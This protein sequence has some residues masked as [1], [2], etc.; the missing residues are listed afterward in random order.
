MRFETPEQSSRK[1]QQAQ[2]NLAAI[3]EAHAQALRD[4]R[5]HRNRMH[6]LTAPAM[7]NDEGEKRKRQGQIAETRKAIDAAIKQRDDAR[8]K[9][10]GAKI[11]ARQAEASACIELVDSAKP[12][13]SKQVS[14]YWRERLQRI[15]AEA[16]A[17]M[18]AFEIREA[19]QI[20]LGIHRESKA[21]RL[22]VTPRMIQEYERL[23]FMR[24]DVAELIEAGVV[25][26]KDVPKQLA[27][28][29]NI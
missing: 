19:M 18:Q 27:K 28:A 15:E 26:S 7:P 6:Q 17:L 13:Y 12:D 11:D 22:T 2:K 9:L 14:A 3:Q 16:L 1:L 8:G 25:E 5:D 29:W 4:L 23:Q 21:A 10:E 20:S 24:D